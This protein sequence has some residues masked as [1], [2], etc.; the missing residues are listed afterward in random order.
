MPSK[1]YK[2]IT[3]LV[4]KVLKEPLPKTIKIRKREEENNTPT[5][6]EIGEKENKK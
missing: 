1:F 4:E 6:K 5:T 3:A 2:E